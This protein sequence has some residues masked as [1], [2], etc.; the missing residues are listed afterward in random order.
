MNPQV[1]IIY[2]A[3]FTAYYRWHAYNKVVRGKGTNWIQLLIKLFLTSPPFMC[4]YFRFH[5]TMKRFNTFDRAFLPSFALFE[6][7]FKL[8]LRRIYWKI[9][10]FFLFG[11]EKEELSTVYNINTVVKIYSKTWIKKLKN[12]NTVW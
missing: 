8:L 9:N 6:R 12:T 2:R 10:R 11:V 5:R 4:I 1:R 3:P 7:I